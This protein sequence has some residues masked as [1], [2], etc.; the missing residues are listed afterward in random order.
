MKECTSC[1]IAKDI[2]SFYKDAS[3]PDGMT[4]QC[5]ECRKER[6]R[7]THAK[8]KEKRNFNRKYNHTKKLYGVDYEAYQNM[9]VEQKQKCGICDEVMKKPVVDHCHKSGKARML[10]CQSCNIMLGMA[11]DNQNIFKSAIKY[12]QKF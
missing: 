7:Q 10:L 8:H 2:N 6:S 9:L 1:K 12:L 3:Q 5:K 4:A 11:K